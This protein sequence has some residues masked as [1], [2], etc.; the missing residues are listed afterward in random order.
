M[1]TDQINAVL[2]SDI[3]CKDYASYVCAKDECLNLSLDGMTI[4]VSNTDTS[5]Q[6]GTH[7]F[8]LF[9]S[10]KDTIEYF[11][12]YGSIGVDTD[13]MH[14]IS[15]KFL[16][17]I[18]NTQRVQGFNTSVC[19]QYCLIYLLLRVRGYSMNDIITMLLSCPNIEVRDH[20]VNR[21]INNTFSSI[22]GTF[23][24]PHDFSFLNQSEQHSVTDLCQL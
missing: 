19:G 14:M 2:R 22:L 17:A 23:F 15:S 3:F 8:A 6:P 12:S 10:N 21:F 13:I 20:S 1:D 16:N 18:S 11:D 7:W 5:D 9:C 24:T 4:V